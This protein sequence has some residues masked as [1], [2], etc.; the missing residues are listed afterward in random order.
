MDMQKTHRFWAIIF[1]QDHGD[2]FILH[3]AQGAGGGL[4]FMHKNR[5]AGHDVPG[6]FFKELGVQMAAKI[7]IGDDT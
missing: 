7:A 4:V 2:A 5:V 6:P 3:E 1:H